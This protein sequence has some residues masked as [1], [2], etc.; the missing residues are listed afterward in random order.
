M[1]RTYS[2]YVI[3][4]FRENSIRSVTLIDD[5]VVPYHTLIKSI[6]Q[7]NLAIGNDEKE[8]IDPI[9]LK[10][11]MN[12]SSISE[13][14]LQKQILCDIDNAAENIDHEK[15]RKSDLIIL[16]YHLV[17]GDS[18]KSREL[19]YNLS[20]TPHMN[21]V[22]IYTTDD[23]QK[24][25]KELALSL[26]GGVIKEFS[27]DV[28]E[29]WEDLC[30]G[31]DIPVEFEHLI[32]Q[33]ELDAIPFTRELSR[34]VRQEVAKQLEGS[35]RQYIPMIAKKL[36]FEFLSRRAG[37]R[38]PF[39]EREIQGSKDKV[40]WLQV[41]SVFVTFYKKGESE[42]I[43]NEPNELWTRLHDALI[44]WGPTY[45]QLMLS[46]IQNKLEDQNL[47][48]DKLIS[49]GKYEQSAML[50]SMLHGIQ[51][52]STENPIQVILKNVYDYLY[53]YS[54]SD[55]S[56]HKFLINAA[57]S[58][59]QD[60]PESV[61]P[62]FI[63]G[64]A[65]PENKKEYDEYQERLIEISLSNFHSS[66][67]YQKSQYDRLNVVH[68]FN[69][70]LS[71]TEV[72]SKYITTGMLFRERKDNAWYLCVSPSCNTVSRQLTDKA[73]KR[74]TPNR[75]L[76]FLELEKCNLQEALEQATQSRY[77]FTLDDGEPIA[78]GVVHAITN[79]PII[80]VGIVHDHDAVDLSSDGKVVSFIAGPSDN[81]KI[82]L[83]EKTLEPVGQVKESYAARFQ[84]IQSHYEGRIGVDFVPL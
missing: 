33:E 13:F 15:I 12:A 26:H 75:A 56:L 31:N 83:E 80:E 67:E 6:Q 82:E 38:T 21:L 41:G 60:L 24:V 28:E 3:E 76:R 62:T 5:Q 16:D 25:W 49:K 74:M 1:T 4:S 22:V 47:P 45:Y 77:I 52:K 20:T 17:P 10:E 84:N 2:E 59:E 65:I 7:S 37:V 70:E 63:A 51:S 71:S 81:A 44:E 29:L 54:L 69:K 72:K 9:D 64:N 23:L 19:V 43:E 73:S 78:L 18:Q 42:R 39:I 32:S 66:H 36:L 50:W 79:L 55:E 58:V 57:S 46:E 11:S 53:G 27:E 30:N 61:V 34:A 48:M 8:M 35:K 40:L 14:F 68:A